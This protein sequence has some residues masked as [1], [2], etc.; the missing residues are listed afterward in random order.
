[1][2]G[3]QNFDPRQVEQ[4]LM[5]NTS[6]ENTALRGIAAK[7]VDQQLGAEAAPGAIDVTLPERGAVMTFTRSLQV[8]GG[9]P[10]ELNLEVKR[11]ART[12]LFVSA[13]LL[14]GIGAIAVLAGKRDTST[15]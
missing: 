7:I 2:Q 4:L 14:L 13:L 15:A 9:A 5:G 1:M 6:D 10:L 12:N 3:K 11:I 8:D